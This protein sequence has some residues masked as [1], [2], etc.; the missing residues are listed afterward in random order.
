MEITKTN[1]LISLNG[2]GKSYKKYRG[3]LNTLKGIFAKNKNKYYEEKWVLQDINLTLERG[4]SIGIVGKNGSGK[5]TLLQIICGTM[6]ATRGSKYINGKI[7]ALLELGS[8]FNPEFTG[9]ENIYLNGAIQGMKRREVERKL[10]DILEFADIGEAVNEP[11]KTY[12][13]GMI[14]RLAFAVMANVDSDILII[15]EALAVGD[16]LFTQKCMRYI[17]RVRRIKAYFL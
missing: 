6:E 10:E 5:S 4:T 1:R 14:V 8:G 7:S 13:S 3:K 9:I 15:D 17:Q 11:V 16:A 2:I 12:S